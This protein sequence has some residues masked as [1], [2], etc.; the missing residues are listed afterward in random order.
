MEAQTFLWERITPLG[1]PVL[2]DVYMM[3]QMSY[4]GEQEKKEENKQK[5]E[6]AAQY[7]SEHSMQGRDIHVSHGQNCQRDY[8]PSSLGGIGS[9][10]FFF[11]NSL[12]SSNERICSPSVPLDFIVSIALGSA[13]VPS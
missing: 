2:P 11:P 4:I 10:L 12:T 1:A 9:D 7:I 13:L 3:Q 6:E 8:L 5:T